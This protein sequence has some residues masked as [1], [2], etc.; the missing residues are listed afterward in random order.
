MNNRPVASAASREPLGKGAALSLL[1][2]LCLAV[3][4]AACAPRY[5]EPPSDAYYQ[6][7]HEHRLRFSAEPPRIQRLSDDTREM[8][9]ILERARLR[10]S[11]AAQRFLVRHRRVEEF[12]AL[13]ARKARAR[14]TMQDYQAARNRFLQDLEARAA[15]GLARQ[16]A[17]RS[18][19]EQAE[20]APRPTL[21][22][23]LR[24]RRP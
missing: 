5:P 4:V 20:Q 1:A 9:A 16:E 7:L 21:D 15:Q 13:E 11:P 2:V 17:R 22:D 12:W 8:E 23:L 10:R 6:A 18:M 19:V 24:D 3:A 14:T